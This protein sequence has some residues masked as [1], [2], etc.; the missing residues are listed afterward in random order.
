MIDL[1]FY[2]VSEI[3]FIRINGY[4]IN[5]SNSEYGNLSSPIE[6][7]KLNYEGVC[8]EFPDLKNNHDWNGEAIKRFKEKIKSFKN[9]EEIS[10]YLIEDLK[11]YG[12]VPKF[13]QKAG[14]RREVIVNG[15]N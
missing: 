7:L 13:K 6:G 3:I 5:F 12:F 9:E 4:D 1:I 11:K 10:N 14:F 8:K 2:R 15:G